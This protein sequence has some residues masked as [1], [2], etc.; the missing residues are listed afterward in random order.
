MKRFQ[1]RCII[2]GTKRVVVFPNNSAKQREYFLSK[3]N[4]RETIAAI[5]DNNDTIVPKKT[6]RK[7]IDVMYN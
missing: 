2:S 4:N 6:N 1:E 7:V 3:V 5:E